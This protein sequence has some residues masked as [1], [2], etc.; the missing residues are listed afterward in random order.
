[1]VLCQAQ[2][3]SLGC[4]QIFS[5]LIPA[6]LS[7]A[8]IFPKSWNS[9]KDEFG[10]PD[11][12]SSWQAEQRPCWRMSWCP[13]G[14]PPQMGARHGDCPRSQPSVAVPLDVLA[15]LALAA[16]L[17]LLRSGPMSSPSLGHV[18]EPHKDCRY[19]TRVRRP[20]CGDDRV[21]LTSV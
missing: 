15:R 10:H 8:F 20:P 16:L 5:R 3:H 1:M 11:P 21:P 9:P 17:P 7:C 19:L 6:R 2:S 14:A 13:W 12:H 18:P 4:Y